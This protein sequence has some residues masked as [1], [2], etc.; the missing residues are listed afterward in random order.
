MRAISERRKERRGEEGKRNLVDETMKR[1]VHWF[2][3]E[4]LILHSDRGEH[5]LAIEIVMTRSFPELQISQVRRREEL[6][7]MLKDGGGDGWRVRESE[8][9]GGRGRAGRGL[10]A[11]C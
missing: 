10:T 2:E 1:T 5:I 11:R 4:K 6:V 7:T 3:L 9:G 8:E